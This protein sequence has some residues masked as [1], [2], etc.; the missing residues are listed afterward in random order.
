MKMLLDILSWPIVVWLEIRLWWELRKFKRL[1]REN[2]RLLA[3][4]ERCR[5][6]GE[7]TR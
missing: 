1:K 3:Q 5:K 7:W 6:A 2:I 4:L